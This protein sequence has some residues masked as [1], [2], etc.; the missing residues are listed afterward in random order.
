[1][2]VTLN[3]DPVSGDTFTLAPGA[4]QSIFTTLQSLAQTL[5]LQSG[6]SAA[7]AKIENGVNEAMQNVDQALEHVL[8]VRSD[9]GAK[10]RELDALT[11]TDADRSLQFDQTL[12]RLEDLDY[13]KAL[14]YFAQQQAALDAAQKSFLRVT[15]L[16]LFNYM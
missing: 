13:A 15:S 14:S 2:Q 7:S 4:P 1:M 11:T 8:A 16:S 6:S 10:L 3:G 12:S 5:Q 9:I